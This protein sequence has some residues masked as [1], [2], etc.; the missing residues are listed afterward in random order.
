M[1]RRISLWVK[2]YPLVVY[3]ILAYV[4]T[5]II[6]LPVVA[7]AQGFIS[8]PTSLYAL[9]Y[10]SAYGPLL[11]AVIVTGITDGG[12]GLR[13]LLGRMIKWR[14]GLGW[15]LVAA[16][17][18]LVLFGLA[19]LI[20][21]A[22]VG[23]A[24]PDLSLA[25]QVNFLPYL[26]I[27]ALVLWLFTSGIGEESGWR[28]YALPRLQRNMSALSATLILTVFWVFWHLSRFFYFGAFVE[29]GFSVLPLFALQLL[30]MGIVLTWLYNSTNGSI[31]M[32]AL[33]HG[34]FNFLPAGAAA[35]GYIA[36]TARV[37]LIIWA[38]VVVAVFKPANLS[39]KGK[40]TQ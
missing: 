37:L 30:A 36:P 5:W 3:F 27:G 7:S 24:P 11:A 21:L 18:P 32:A 1:S 20:V 13:E 34:G 9:H 31:M 14:V 39:R 4:I 26:G 17:S 8:V 25:G 28:G 33:F 29:L 6:V 19:A 15:V 2:E 35:E 10:L 23:G 22:V 12:D 40:Q 38:V 16:L